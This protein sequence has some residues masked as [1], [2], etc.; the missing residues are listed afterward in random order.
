MLVN[1]KYGSFE[2]LKNKFGADLLTK[3]PD[4]KGTAM[5]VQ[6]HGLY[7]VLEDGTLQ[8]IANWYELPE[9]WDENFA[10]KSEAIKSFEPTSLD[11][12][13]HEVTFKFADGTDAGT[14]DFGD[15]YDQ[16]GAFRPAIEKLA[17]KGVV[18]SDDA[19]KLADI[20][21]YNGNATE[22]EKVKYLVTK[23]YVDKKT[24]AV[25]KFSKIVVPDKTKIGFNSLADFLVVENGALPVDDNGNQFLALYNK[26]VQHLDDAVSDPAAAQESLVAQT[27]VDEKVESVKSKLHTHIN[28]TSTDKNDRVNWITQSENAYNQIQFKIADAAIA[29][30]SN[31]HDSG[32][33]IATDLYVDE[34]IKETLDS[35]VTFKGVIS[36]LPADPTNGDMYKAGNAIEGLCNAGDTIIYNSATAKWEVIAQDVNEAIED[37]WRALKVDNVEW[38]NEKLTSGNANFVHGTNISLDVEGNDLTINVTP[39]DSFTEGEVVDGKVIGD[40]F[41][42]LETLPVYRKDGDTYTT[43]DLIE[44]TDNNDPLVSQSGAQHLIDEA[45]KPIADEAALHTTISTASVGKD[46]PLSIVSTTESD[47]HLN[48]TISLSMTDS[49]QKDAYDKLVTSGRIYDALE[50]IESSLDIHVKTEDNQFASIANC[51]ES[52]G[53]GKCLDLNVAVSNH[54]AYIPTTGDAL[55][56]VSFVEEDISSFYD[57]KVQPLEELPVQTDTDIITLSEIAEEDPLIAK[58]YVDNALTWGTF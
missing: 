34:K 23:E 30:S 47:G 32:E 53:S 33:K 2:A 39:S 26:I 43:G 12:D 38:L 55:A 35:E 18:T 40:H 54:P 7:M 6:D 36:E 50:S 56:S 48:Y 15:F 29:H 42:T 58:S 21:E 1:F 13:N 25:D 49:V 41:D 14:I 37:T 16:L 10:L 57:E 31:G 51:T 46:S 17:N 24:D 11:A 45:L 8:K 28:A 22:A 44:G 27:Y 19:I 20:T 4:L 52:D 9:S 3:V 5:F